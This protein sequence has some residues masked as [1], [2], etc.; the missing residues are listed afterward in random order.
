[1]EKYTYQIK[2]NYFEFQ[3]ID[4]ILKKRYINHIRQKYMKIS[5]CRNCKNN[6]FHNLLEEII[7]KLVKHYLKKTNNE[8]KKVQ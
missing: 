6:K 3:I 4:E 7:P 2:I 1:M 8:H 5:F